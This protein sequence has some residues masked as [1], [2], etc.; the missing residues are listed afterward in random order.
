MPVRAKD[1]GKLEEFN[2]VKNFIA[3]A[4]ESAKKKRTVDLTLK[5][6]LTV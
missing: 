2:E 1:K 6:A 5:I 4:P 3:E